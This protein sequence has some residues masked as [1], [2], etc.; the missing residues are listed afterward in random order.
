MDKREL[1]FTVV[2]VFSLTILLYY[3]GS[4][5]TGF[6]TQSMYCEDGT[7]KEF[8]KFNSDCTAADEFCCQKEDFGICESSSVCKKQYTF[9]PEEVDIE[10]MSPLEKPAPTKGRIAFYSVLV[11]LTVF[12]GVIYFLKRKRR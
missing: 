2:F 9:H 5:I 11:A 6:A 1:L 4:S 10:S 8:C 3:L 12:I 7:C